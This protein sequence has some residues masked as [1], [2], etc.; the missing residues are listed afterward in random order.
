[1][2]RLLQIFG[3]L[4]VLLRGASL[5]L[6]SLIVGG[7]VFLLLVRGSGR[8]TEDIRDLCLGWTRRF[9][10]A[11]IATETSYLVT[12]AFI[13]MQSVEIGLSDIIGAN[14]VLAGALGLGA[15]FTIVALSSTGRAR[16]HRGFLLPAAA[17]IASSVLTS[18]AM[19]RLEHRLPLVFVTALH[20]LATAAW[21]GALPFLLMAIR[22][23]SCPEFVRQLCARFSR[24]GGL[25]PCY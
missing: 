14:F 13:L 17:I 7:V 23:A 19:A 16:S 11:L 18:H 6:Q 5:T 2:A 9:A 21:L 3:F 20:Q 24:L 25:T 10:L 1:M 12:N 22:R 15:C 4:S 8:N